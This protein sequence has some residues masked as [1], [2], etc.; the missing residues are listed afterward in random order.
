VSQPA[1]TLAIRKMEDE[2]GGPL[3]ER[4]RNNIH[5]T[6]LGLLL[7]PQLNEALTRT[8][9]AKAA[10][11]RFLRLE[12]A[13]LSLGVMCTIG[14]LRFVGFLS[15]FRAENPG[16]EI[17]L[18]EAPAEQLCQMLLEG[19]LDV[20][21]IARPAGFD[22]PLQASVLYPERFFIACSVGHKF[23]RQN[24]VQIAELDGQSYLVRINCEYFDFLRD[25]CRSRG[26]RLVHCFRSERED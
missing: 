4:E 18:M 9:A 12:G 25:T 17:T 1:L 5:L 19:R 6:P 13:H 7:E 14:P 24:S 26:S 22:A 11:T 16:I 2:L 3:F 15:R 8:E 10:A 20:A 21:L 23:A